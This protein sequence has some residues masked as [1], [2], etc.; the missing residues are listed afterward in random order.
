LFVAFPGE[1]LGL[2]VAW[3]DD[4]GHFPHWDRPRAAIDVIL[5]V[6]AR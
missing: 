2:G 1:P 5:A 3:L 6:T 4:A